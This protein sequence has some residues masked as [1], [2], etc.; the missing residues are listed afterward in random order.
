MD[1]EPPTTSAPAPDEPSR[2]AAAPLAS[3]R[4]VR[5]AQR[6]VRRVEGRLRR[7]SRRSV[8]WRGRR[9][10]YLVGLLA[11]AGGTG[12]FYVLSQVELPDEIDIEVSQTSYVC[13]GDVPEGCDADNALAQLS[14]EEDRVVVAYDEL[15]ANLVNAVVA[16]EDR[17]FF[18]HQG[19]D[20][21]GILR[22]AYQGVR[23]SQSVQGGSTIT[24]QYV[25]LEFLTPERTVIRK[26][27]EISMA[28]K[29]ERRLSKEEILQRYLNRIYFGRGA[30]GVAAASR[31]YFG[32]NID[33]LDLSD[34]AYLA[35]LIR[36]PESTDASRD[37]ETATRRRNS[38][39]TGMFEEGYITAADA[40]AARAVDLATSVVPRRE[41]TGGLEDVRYAEVGSEYFVD[42]VRN[43][44]L[45]RYGP[46]VYTMGLRVYT[47]LDPQ[48]QTEAYESATAILA[49]PDD[50]AAGLVSLD[51][52]GRVVAMV[53][54][55]DH[56]TSQVNLALGR[57]G[58]GSGRQPGSSFKAIA[59]AEALEQNISIDSRFAAP[60]EIVIP[61][62][63]AGEDWEVSGG[64][65]PTGIYDL[66]DATT[67][68]SN[69]VYAQL[70]ET[71]GPESV[72]ALAERMGVQADLLPVHALV[73]G[74]GEVSVLDMATA[75]SVFANRGTLRPPR[76]IDRIEDVDGNVLWPTEPFES[77]QVLTPD[78]TDV[79]TAALRSVISSGTGRRAAIP[80]DAAGK[81]G[82]TQDNRDAWF[83]GY[84]CEMTTAVWI[85]YPGRPGED[86]RFLLNVNGYDEVG[87]GTIP[88]ELWSDYMTRATADAEPCELPSSRR[89]EGVVLGRNLTTTTTTDPN[90]TTTTVEDDATTTTA[91]DGGDDG[92]GPDGPGDEDGGGDGGGGD[93]TTTA[94]PTTGPPPTTST[95]SAPPPTGEPTTEET[96]ESDA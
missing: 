18:T 53:G 33:E 80:T 57:Q 24:Q 66:F 88:A 5:R 38:V 71:V 74:S 12:F 91:G 30:Y 93:T 20:P 54:G 62:A 48:R 34:A 7:R 23:G 8:L 90:A 25:K 36:S 9:V 15:P 3:T 13:A 49:D 75:Y 73:L 84:T 81:T 52:A 51:D 42:A 64:G 19:V 45:D 46:D 21:F 79:V 47:T 86:P 22:A 1:D 70:M 29:L 95:T 10:L 78:I 92:D 65:S 43:E 17:D 28:V 56:D 94:P 6:H 31:S 37:P 61:E 14:A 40:E 32:K 35:A 39:I 26:L 27:R 2:P 4:D 69:T 68:S 58:G 63:N 11:I 50:P 77:S 55:T 82:T 44:L 89:S 85:G 76:M 72:V 16:A 60:Y 96:G 83:V 59:L 41:R 67:V 87:G